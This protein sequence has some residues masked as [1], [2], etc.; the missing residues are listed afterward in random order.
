MWAGELENWLALVLPP[1][2]SERYECLESDSD[3]ELDGPSED[4]TV[5]EWTERHRAG[6]QTWSFP[7]NEL[8]A[9]YL[10]SVVDR[11]EADVLALLRLFLFEESCFGKDSE[12]LHE[13]IYVRKDFSQPEWLPNEYWRRLQRWISGSAKPHPSVRWTLDLL[14]RSPGKAVAAI[15]AY[16][17]VY[18]GI[19]PD[20][21]SQGLLDAIAIIR[22]RWVEVIEPGLEAL[23]RLDPRE[24]EVLVG[25]LYRELGYAVEVT[26][27]TKDGGRDVIAKKTAPGFSDIVEIE[28]KA[29]AS[30]VGV[31]IA[32]QL[33]GVVALSRANRG[34]LVTIGRFT[35][36]ALKLADADSRLELI[37]GVELTRI[38]NSAFGP[39]WFDDRVWICRGLDGA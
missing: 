3:S 10:N 6:V 17:E 39:S 8:R 2:A 35:R 19:R 9:E 14:P 4:E 34:V 23:F 26:P 22:A 30:P 27:S 24:L 38:L 36:D 20:G 32:R 15:G 7:T 21:R 13:A 25:A 18:D 33:Q 5:D 1:G 37:D 11:A 28:C 31:R 16:L 12:Y 29:H